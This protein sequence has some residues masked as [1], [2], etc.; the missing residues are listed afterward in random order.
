MA[1]NG[2]IFDMDDTLVR[3]A[4]IWKSAETSL[5]HLMG[6][7]WSAQLAA[8]YKGMNTLDVARVMHK[9]LGS[10]LSLLQCQ[11]HLRSALIAGFANPVEPMPRAIAL[12]RRLRKHFPLAVASGSPLEAIIAALTQLGLVDAF[13]Q[14]ISSES[15]PRGKPHPDVFLH[16]AELLHVPP[17]KC[18]VF[19]DSFIGCQAARAAGMACFVVPS[20]SVDQLRPI[21]TRI[22]S[23]LAQVADEHV[24]QALSLAAWPAVA[25]HRP[26]ARIV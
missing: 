19:E 17:E 13:D 11:Q 9:R 1:N 24:R 12:V 25:C 14:I 3:T 26:S 15:V 5:L 4:P 8:Q 21:A 6:A 18:L 16:A 20:A 7:T 22:Y 2:I 23:S 10:P